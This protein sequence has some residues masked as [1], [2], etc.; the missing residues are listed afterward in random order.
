MKSKQEKIKER[1]Q[2][3]INEGICT[4]LGGNAW[5]DDIGIDRLFSYLGSQGVVILTQ[6]DAHT[7]KHEPLVK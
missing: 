6:Y 2:T 1:A 4:G 5:I 3:I 7:F